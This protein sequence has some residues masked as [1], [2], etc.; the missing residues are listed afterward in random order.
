M[1]ASYNIPYWEGADINDPDTEYATM[2]CVEGS[3]FIRY[4][5]N[6]IEYIE[7]FEDAY[8][9]VNNIVN[10]KTS[11]NS[12]YLD[13]S[14]LDIKIWDSSSN[15]YVQCYKFIRN[16]NVRNW[17]IVKF[18]NGYSVTATGDHPLPVEGKGRTMVDDLNCGDKI[19]ISEYKR[20][21][22]DRKLKT[23]YFGD[24]AW[25]LGVLIADSAYS[26]SQITVSLGLDETDIADRIE[27]ICEDLGYRADIK[28][29]HR[30]NKGS[31][32]GESIREIPG[33]KDAREE[34][35]MLFGDYPKSKRYLTSKLLTLSREY[36]IKLLAGLIDAD[37][38]VNKSKNRD[39]S[40]R[41]A[42]FSLGSTNKKL[43]MSEL[44]L[45]RGL[46]YHAKLYRNHYSTKHNKIR[47]LIEFEIDTE[48]VNEMASQK[49]IKDTESIDWCSYSDI[50]DV[51]V[52]EVSNGCEENESSDYS[53]DVETESDR[54]DVSGL[55]SHNCRTRVYSNVRDNGIH[56]SVG[57]GNLSFTSINLPRLGLIA[58]HGNIDRFFM[59]L[60]DR[61][62]LV[63]R[64]LL[65][66]F[67]VQC[68]RHP[69]N[70]PFMMGQG[71]W[72][73]S[74][75]LGPDDD[76]RDALSNGTLSVGF[77][78]LA[79]CLVALTGKHHGESEESQALGLKIVGHMRELTDKWSQKEKMNYSVIGTPAEGLS[80]RF[81]NIDKK[82]FG[83]IPGVTD[84][85]YY[86]N[87]SHV[88]VYYP[89]SAF[90]KIDIEAPYHKLENGGCIC[91][92]EFDGD[93]LK[94]LKAFEKI[95][96]YAY[97]KDICYFA[98]N[99][100]VD[101]DPVCGYVGIIDDVC[102]RCGRHDG[103]AMTE[104][105][106]KELHKKYYSNNNISNCGYCGDPA[107]EKDRHRM[108]NFTDQL[109]SNN[110]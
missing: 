2:G 77:I 27:K 36:R 17:R 71:V 3:E 86:T 58:G 110:E 50:T 11:G 65:E 47:Y 61:M 15:N 63:H 23:K 51:A 8:N 29:Q 19:K 32:I 70:Y 106:W 54:F 90:K 60:D 94:N 91:Y 98:I 99:H 64:Q 89:I 7:S 40:Y 41:S 96:Q 20:T 62:E 93:P 55:Q 66:R 88:P 84:R 42:R 68:M 72:K 53:Y 87:S 57:R 14:K 97:D 52:V 43:A 9:R 81:V 92:I 82:R 75:L 30:G 48:I 105:K 79:E 45:I 44:E 107:E 109:K 25:L 69:R 28:E 12:E 6:G 1:S 34:L 5:I 103:E 100:A 21:E 24:Y 38:Y 104:E 56:G 39:G 76:L 33:L 102:P 74:E 85:E 31:Y 59:L 37:G 73:G 78:G 10:V 4:Q 101:R 26:S 49:K 18:D 95:V 67:E 46:G 16:H 83:I 35:A 108:A 13:T 80:G 22:Y